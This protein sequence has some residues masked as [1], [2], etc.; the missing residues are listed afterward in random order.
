MTIG[1]GGSAPE[2]ELNKLQY[3]TNKATTISREEYQYR[4]KKVQSLTNF[5]LT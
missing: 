1:V 5:S 4:I 2:I 3:M